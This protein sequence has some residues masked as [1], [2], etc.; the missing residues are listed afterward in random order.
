MGYLR[1]MDQG[2]NKSLKVTRTA[3]V[4]TTVKIGYDMT[5]NCVIIP[6]SFQIAVMKFT[7]REFNTAVTNH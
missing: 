7:S 3:I 4:I 5:H 2:E 6:D 1:G